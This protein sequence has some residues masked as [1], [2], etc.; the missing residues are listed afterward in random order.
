MHLS[1]TFRHNSS[2]VKVNKL[3][4]LSICHLFCIYIGDQT[5]VFW[6]LGSPMIKR[7]FIHARSRTKDSSLG[8]EHADVW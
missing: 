4:L 7:A 8:I 3:A 5:R 6:L 2:V 1:R